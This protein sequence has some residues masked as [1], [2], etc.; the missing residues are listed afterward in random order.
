MATE[1]KTGAR[2]GTSDPAS[3]ANREP[4]QQPRPR[5]TEPRPELRDKVSRF[6]RERDGRAR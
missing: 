6:L 4:R 2:S 5:P 3:N 1:V